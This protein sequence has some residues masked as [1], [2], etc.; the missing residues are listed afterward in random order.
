MKPYIFGRRNQIHIIDLKETVKG[1]LR[2]RR[3]LTSAAARGG[4]VLFVGTKR[5][6]RQT[7]REQA[8]RCG[9]PYVSERWLGGALTNFRTVLSRLSRLEELERM[10]TD[11][12]WETLS[13]KEVSSL[14]RELRKARRNL[15]GL[16]TMKS[17]PGALLVVDPRHERIAVREAVKLGIPIVALTDTDSNP[18]FI[19]IV[20]P[21]NDD[22][23]RSVSLVVRLLTD[24]VGEGVAGRR[25]PVQRGAR[26]RRAEPEPKPA[27]S[28]AT[29]GPGTT[30]VTSEVGPVRAGSVPQ[31]AA[32][33]PTSEGGPDDE[34][35]AS[36][37]GESAP[38]AS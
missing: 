32:E 22:A 15:G 4:D 30:A 13:K 27:A 23:L 33:A 18:Q 28:A 37:A 34:P 10:E 29:P 35:P 24:A 9:M 8:Q 7:I 5:Q 3:F 31:S 36:S 26:G 6:A 19:D 17:L 25:A 12:T 16:R 11:G 21:G 2:A 38:A 1:F 20:I 14:R